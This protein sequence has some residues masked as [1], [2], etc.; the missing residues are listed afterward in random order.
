MSEVMR[1]TEEF[2]QCIPQVNQGKNSIDTIN[3]M[4]IHRRQAVGLHQTITWNKILNKNKIKM[5]RIMMKT[6]KMMSDLRN[7]RVY[8]LYI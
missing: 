5:M 7:D 3:K 6:M 2:L 8:V 4:N 1:F